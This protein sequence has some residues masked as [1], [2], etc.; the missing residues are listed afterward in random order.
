MGV[1]LLAHT[2]VIQYSSIPH[3]S[4]ADACRHA[5]VAVGQEQL[6]LGIRGQQGH[7]LFHHCGSKHSGEL[8]SRAFGMDTVKPPQ[9]P[10]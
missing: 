3:D 5:A 7:D 2:R 1:N 10:P 4:T 6:L 8:A 9:F